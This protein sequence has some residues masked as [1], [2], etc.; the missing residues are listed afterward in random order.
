MISGHGQGFQVSEEEI[1]M[2]LATFRTTYMSSG[3]SLE[4]VIILL[5][6]EKV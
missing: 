4:C 2:D 3:G 1:S 6:Q 5:S